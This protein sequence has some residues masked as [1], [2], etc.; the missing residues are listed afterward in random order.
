MYFLGID[1]G[2]KNSAYTLIQALDMDR[3][4]I[5]DKGIVPHDQLMLLLD[6]FTDDLTYEE[7]LVSI[8]GMQ[9]F[10][11]AVGA[12]VF[13]TCYNIGEY[14]LHCK[15]ADM[16]HRIVFRQT[17]KLHHCKSVRAKDGNIRQAL[18]DRF[19]EPGVKAAQGILYKVAK[20]MWSSTAIA[21][22]SFDEQYA[23]ARHLR[24]S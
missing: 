24:E 1:P 16:A 14:R 20:D 6:D 22:H 21:V 10:G 11:M 13:E 12:S 4:R 18:I 7:M 3:I 23:T 15:R 9:S 5:V 17:I 8:E 2:P 19:G